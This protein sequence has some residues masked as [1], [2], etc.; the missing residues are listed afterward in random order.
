MTSCL[1]GTAFLLF[2]NEQKAKQYGYDLWE[3][4]QADGTFHYTGQG[5]S[6]DQ[7]FRG[8]NKS[9]LA[10]AKDGGPIHLF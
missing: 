9:L 7:K 1:E 3:G 4:W 8:P 10:I 5:A 2:Q 6:G